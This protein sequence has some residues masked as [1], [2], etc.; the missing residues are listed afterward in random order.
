MQRDILF[1]LWKHDKQALE[2]V[3]AWEIAKRLNRTT[4][5][6]MLSLA[7]LSNRDL[8]DRECINGR[9]EVRYIYSLAWFWTD[10]GS[11]VIGELEGD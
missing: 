9:T 7:R 6:I 8:V 2:S 4:T 5:S 1:D 11:A 10:D 3:T